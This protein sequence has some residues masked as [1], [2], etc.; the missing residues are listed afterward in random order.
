[1][2][3]AASVWIAQEIIPARHLRQFLQAGN[4]NT[5]NAASEEVAIFSRFPLFPHRT[6]LLCYAA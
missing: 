4:G 5:P 1:M 3:G 2:R 6:S